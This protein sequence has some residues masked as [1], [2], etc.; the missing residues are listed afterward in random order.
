MSLVCAPTVIFVSPS[1]LTIC[2]CFTVY[3]ADL[4]IWVEV[5]PAMGIISASLPT[6]RPIL[7]LIFRKVGLTQDASS[8]ANTPGKSLV[9]FGRG[10]VRNKSSGYSIAV[11]INQDQD[12]TEHL[13]G[14][15]EEQHGKRTA[16]VGV[17]HGDVELDHMRANQPQSINVKTEVAW[18]EY[19]AKGRSDEEEAR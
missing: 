16:T 13:S 12:S 15:P 7:T 9:T 6:L 8:R 19:R 1:R 3:L 2:V 5:E 4:I 17:G 14:W 18:K 10:N 11:S